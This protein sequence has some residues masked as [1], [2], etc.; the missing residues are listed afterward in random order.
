[1]DVFD[2]LETSS[3]GSASP[4]TRRRPFTQVPL[5]VDRLKPTT[6]KPSFG[7]MLG[8]ILRRHL[9]PTLSK[10]PVAHLTP[11]LLPELAGLLG[12]LLQPHGAWEG[13]ARPSYQEGLAA[14][15]L[16]RTAFTMLT[17]STILCCWLTS[18]QLVDPTAHALSVERI[19]SHHT[20]EYIAMLFWSSDLISVVFAS[21]AKSFFGHLVFWSSHVIGISPN[22]VQF[23]RWYVQSSILALCSTPSEPD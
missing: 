3:P 11:R 5:K 6:S 14:L 21:L 2:I 1:M 4:A 7:Q 22:V 16:D 23:S 8:T 19:T 18:T 20:P 9:Q 17:P 10:T 12:Q 15:H 13:Q